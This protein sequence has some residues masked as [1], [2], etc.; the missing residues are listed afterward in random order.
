MP[1]LREVRASLLMAHANNMIDD[2][3]FVFLY[4]LN[5]SKNPDFP[6]WNYD[7]FD[8]DKLTDDECKAEFRFYK[9]DIYVLKDVLNIPDVFK[10]KNRL[11][12]DGIEAT[13]IFLKRYAYPIRFGDMVHRFGATHPS[14]SRQKYFMPYPA[15]C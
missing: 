4:D 14:R 11:N 12:V 6:Y 1:S 10:C 5:R 13:C 9:N 3:E 2:E 15:Y 8:L 7:N